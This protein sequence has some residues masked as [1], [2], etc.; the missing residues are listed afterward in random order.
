MKSKKPIL[1]TAV[2]YGDI[3]KNFTV[4]QLAWIG[5]VAMAYNEAEGN[6]HLLTGSFLGYHGPY[7]EVTSRINGTEGLIA[8]ILSVLPKYNLAPEVLESF[9]SALQEGFP[10][11]KTYRDA[12][13]HAS[14]M[15]MHTAVA[16]SRP[17]RGARTYTILT[18]DAL[19]GLYER[20]ISVREELLNLALIANYAD[21]LT[22]IPSKGNQHTA[23][24][25][26][27]I[28]DANAQCQSHRKHRQS[29]PPFPKFPDQ[30]KIHE[31][32]PSR[33]KVA[34][35]PPGVP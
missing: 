5:A 25:Q 34:K 8:L 32:E 11:L 33:P 23:R 2:K 17:N 19:E 15:D 10:T 18:E 9:T 20:L 3:K 12:V 16:E 7:L 24:M 14:L 35:P 31:L 4:N 27:G 22:F 28:L 13:I 30:P 26:Q 21:A 6:L 29:L 1:Q